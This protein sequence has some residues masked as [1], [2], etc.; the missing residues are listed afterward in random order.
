MDAQH[1]LRITPIK[2][3]IFL[4]QSCNASTIFPGKYLFIAT[5]WAISYLET[6]F[7]SNITKIEYN[8]EIYAPANNYR[9]HVEINIEDVYI[10]SY[11]LLLKQETCQVFDSEIDK[12]PLDALTSK[13]MNGI[14]ERSITFV[15][16]H[17]P[18]S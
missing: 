6:A 3:V 2:F 5:L 8:R 14:F 1:T 17:R 9:V 15:S 12:H 7:V 10:F 16:S 4:N 11:Q 13:T 18:A